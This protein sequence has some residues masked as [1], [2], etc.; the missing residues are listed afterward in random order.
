[1]MKIV[2]RSGL[3]GYADGGVECYYGI[4]YAALHLGER[5]SASSLIEG[6]R[7][8]AVSALSEVPVFPQLPSRLASSMGSGLD[9]NPQSESAFFLNVWTP[10][11]SLGCPVLFFIHGGAWMT[12]GGSAP[13][14]DGA[15][16]S[17]RGVVV[18]TFNYRLGPFAHLRDD[19]S[20]DDRNPAFS[21][22]L[23]ALQWVHKNIA[24]FGGDPKRVTVAGQSAGSWYAHLLSTSDSAR[25]ML[26]R[27][28]HLSHASNRPWAPAYQDQLSDEVRRELGT[29]SLRSVDRTELLEAAKRVV[30]RRP[31]E[32]GAVPT[33]YLPTT[34]EGTADLFCSATE[35]ARVSHV[36]AVYIRTTGTETSTFFFDSPQ[37]RQIDAEAV[38]A[39]RVSLASRP[40]IGDTDGVV[41]NMENPYEDLVAVTSEYHFG[42]PSRDLADAYALQGIP[43]YLRVFEKQSSLDGF[44]SGHCFDLP[45]QF[46]QM[47]PWT[48]APM[49]SGVSPDEFQ[50]VSDVLMSELVTFVSSQDQICELKSHIQGANPVPIMK[51]IERI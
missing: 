34:N 15:S 42:G 1:M 47:G 33:P 10:I 49:L 4:Q 46:G 37:L 11:Q 14:Y 36:E 51:G 3:T 13:W 29:S 26:A 35:S 16:M 39:L 27:V 30:L 25:G 12:G 9:R 23:A 24:R 22:V 21:D 7:Q 44:L 31:L 38:A 40:T 6:D 48:D 43:T 19:Y 5:F 2:A 45:F 17:A 28:A 50:R 8:I 20:N 41:A 18:V 32:L